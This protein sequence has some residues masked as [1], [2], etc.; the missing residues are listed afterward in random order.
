MCD[1]KQELV[2]QPRFHKLMMLW[3]GDTLSQ[4][5]A[6]PNPALTGLRGLSVPRPLAYALLTQ[7]SVSDKKRELVQQLRFHKFMRDADELAAW[8]NEKM[9]V[10][11]MER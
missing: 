3:S 11:C 4:R 1:I 8:I 5:A 2:Q 6:A 9:Q 10:S 7:D